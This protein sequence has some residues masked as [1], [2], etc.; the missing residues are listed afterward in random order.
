[1]KR[2]RVKVIPRSSRNQVIETGAGE[3]KVKLTAPPV[4][5]KANEALITVLADFL[6][7]RK[8]SL[9]I[10][11]GA[12]SRNKIIEWDDASPSPLDRRRRSG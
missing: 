1:M 7:I 11:Q 3:L 8:S 5:G 10:V 4:E 9:K 6:N 12:T 2:I